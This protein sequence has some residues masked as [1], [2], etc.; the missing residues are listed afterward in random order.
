MWPPIDLGLLG[1][2]G[3]SRGRRA[4]PPGGEL[5]ASGAAH[6]KKSHRIG[7]RQGEF[8]GAST[9]SGVAR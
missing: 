4:I 1:P 9:G 8:G 3:P 2:W 5:R 6:G 7:G